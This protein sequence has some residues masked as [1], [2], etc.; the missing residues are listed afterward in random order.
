MF[1]ASCKNSNELLVKEIEP[2]DS[3]EYAQFI[4]T[5]ILMEASVSDNDIDYYH[6][7]SDSAWYFSYNIRTSLYK[8]SDNLILE[9]MEND[10]VVQQIDISLIKDYYEN[11]DYL[12]Y[13]IDNTK[14]Y[15]F[16]VSSS[17]ETDD[18]IDYYLSINFHSNFISKVEIEPNNTFSLAQDII[19]PNT[20]IEGF[21]TKSIIDNNMKLHVKEDDI[22][23][24]DVYKIENVLNKNINMRIKLDYSDSS[25]AKIVLF[26]DNYNYLLDSNTTLNHRFTK[27]SIL[28][29][30]VFLKDTDFYATPYY[31]EYN[32]Y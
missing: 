8:T 2:N 10:E 4:D 22:I 16:K 13:K 17:L 30:V 25:E 18:I 32:T 6:I 7:K 20:K 11:M 19:S 3:L 28:Y 26:D 15:Y 5:S 31:I 21:F 24:I 27:G 29:V 12:I 14:N 1:I 23:D 9:L